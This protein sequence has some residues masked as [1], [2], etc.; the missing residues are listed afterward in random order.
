[1]ADL[2]AAER[3]A[4]PDSDFALPGRHYPIHDEAH[5]R[6]ALSRGA[7]HASPE[8]LA[9]IKRKVKARY[10]TIKVNKT[11]RKAQAA[12][13]KAAA[14]DIRVPVWKDDTRQIVYGVVLVPDQVDSQ[15][16]VI[17]KEEI[18]KAAHRFLERS[19]KHDV[20]HDENPAAV[21]PVESFIAP[22]DFTLG[23]QRVLKGSWVMAVHVTDPKVWKRVQKG[24]NPLDGFS[25]GGTGERTPIAA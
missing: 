6:A 24:E 12:I 19:R 7:Q 16:D 9:T 22:T 4:L 10:P 3:D 2:T 8:E 23:T 18:E 15:G 25:I 21:A 5:A 14:V 20:Q 11:V 13:A 17:S 1:M